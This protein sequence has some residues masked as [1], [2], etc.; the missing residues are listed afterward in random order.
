MT[1][2]GDMRFVMVGSCFGSFVTLPEPVG[3]GKVSTPERK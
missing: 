1:K 3:L 2:W